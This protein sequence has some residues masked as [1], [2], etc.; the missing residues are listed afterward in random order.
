MKIKNKSGFAFL[1][2]WVGLALA[3]AVATVAVVKPVQNEVKKAASYITSPF[4]HKAQIGKPAVSKATV[5]PKPT[6]NSTFS[7]FAG[8]GAFLGLASIGL[9]IFKYISV[10]QSLEG[11]AAGITIAFVADHPWLSLFLA[12]IAIATSCAIKNQSSLPKIV[13]D[14]ENGVSGVASVVATEVKQIETKI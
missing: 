4:T 10:L 12:S 8:I 5:I 2:L 9:G 3:A 7:W 1:I 6:V 14:V 11:L 13:K